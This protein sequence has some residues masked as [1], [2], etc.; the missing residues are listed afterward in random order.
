MEIKFITNTPRSDRSVLA[1][2]CSV[3]HTPLDSLNQGLVEIVGHQLVSGVVWVLPVDRVRG[4]IKASEVIN[5][6]NGRL[7]GRLCGH[8]CRDTLVQGNDTIRCLLTKLGGSNR[9]QQG[10]LP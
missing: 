5:E 8:P 3:T 4:G 7:R 6:D 9:N 2:L 10:E 1:F